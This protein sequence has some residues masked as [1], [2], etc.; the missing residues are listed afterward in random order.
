MTDIRSDKNSYACAVCTQYIYCKNYIWHIPTDS[1]KVLHYSQDL[2][3]HSNKFF[4]KQLLLN[5][6]DRWVWKKN[7]PCLHKYRYKFLRR[8]RRYHRHHYLPEQIYSFYKRNNTG[9]KTRIRK[10]S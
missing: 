9:N 1:V 2:H 10:C 6:F 8:N 4:R 7:T 5:R 3:N